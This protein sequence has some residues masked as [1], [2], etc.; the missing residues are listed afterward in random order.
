MERPAPGKE[1]QA[2][3]LGGGEYTLIC[4]P[5]GE[6]VAEIYHYGNYDSYGDFLAA[7]K[8]S[9]RSPQ[10]AKLVWEGFCDLYQKHWKD[11]PAIKVSETVWHLGDNTIDG[12]HY[13]YE[14][15][16]DSSQLVTSARLHAD[17]PKRPKSK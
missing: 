16:L 13:Y 4:D 12:V 17:D 14:F 3:G 5:D 10:D 9:I 7:K 8:I 1:K 6:L 2:L 11:N 15:V